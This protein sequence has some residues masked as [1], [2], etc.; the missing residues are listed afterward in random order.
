MMDSSTLP[1][2]SPLDGKKIVVVGAGIAGLSFVVSLRRSW[3]ED[4]GDFPEVVHYEREDGMPDESRERYSVR[5][6]GARSSAGAHALRK[7]RI[8]ETT[9][10]SGIIRPGYARGHTHGYI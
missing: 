10:N 9:L 2:L 5:I 6:R 4:L 1:A 7:M 3:T 8:L